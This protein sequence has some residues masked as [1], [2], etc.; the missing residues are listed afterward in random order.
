M[1]IKIEIKE[2]HIY[3]DGRRKTEDGSQDIESKIIDAVQAFF[4][5]KNVEAKKETTETLR[6]QSDTKEEDGSGKTEVGRR[7]TEDGSQKTED[8][9][10]STT[11]EKPVLLNP[12]TGRPE[13]GDPFN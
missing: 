8:G 7:K 12:K 3:V 1:E 2:V 11:L 10:F 9:S 13:Y 6:T 4:I 5:E